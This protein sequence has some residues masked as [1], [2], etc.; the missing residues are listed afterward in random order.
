[1]KRT[2]VLSFMLALNMFL[3]LT[4][5]ATSEMSLSEN[6]NSEQFFDY[7]TTLMNDFDVGNYTLNQDIQN[8]LPES[9]SKV[10][11]DTG[12]IFTDIFSTFKSWF[13]E[14]TGL[15]LLVSW[16]NSFP[17]LLKS[18]RVPIEITFAVGFF[19]NAL[20]L[21]LIVGVLTGRT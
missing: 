12:N 6:S 3:F 14:T 17:N 13:L 9:Q 15:N 21:Y 18:M 4:Q 20:I 1:M 16:Y 7:R 5:T 10:E 8:L 19:W 2:I 11:P